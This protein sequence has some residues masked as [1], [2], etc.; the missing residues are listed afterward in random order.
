M[1]GHGS[2][3]QPA[4]D[5]V[6][7]A[8][9][10]AV[11]EFA[12]RHVIEAQR[13]WDHEHR[14]PR[15][16]WRAAGEQGLLGLAMPERYGGAGLT[17][18]RFR[19]AITEELAAVGANSLIASINLH[20]DIVLPYLLDLGTDAQRLAL[21]PGCC[22]GGL[23]GAIALTEPGAGSDLRGIT[24]TARRDGDDWILTGSKTSITSGSQADFVIV[25]ARTGVSST[26]NRYTLFLVEAAIPGF[27]RGA[28]LQKIGLHAQD[29]AELF[30]DEIRVPGANVL[31]TAGMGLRHVMERLARERLSIAAFAIARTRAA[32]RW[33]VDYV[34][35]REVFGHPLS[36]M[37][38]TQFVL[39]EVS[40]EVDVGEALVARSAGLLDAGMLTDSAAAKAKWWTTEMQQRCINACLQLHGG[41]GYMTEMPIA[42][43][44]QDARIQTIYGGTT[45]IMKLIIAREMLR[46][47]ARR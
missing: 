38:H 11:R 27:T 41:Y 44:Y 39:A 15:T 22:G 34:Q 46:R 21:I 18:Y 33:T 45:E 17:E 43:A 31:G 24:T 36:E 5:S 37:Q 12:R 16:A 47:P 8:L 1:P 20:D 2:L 3:G 19:R 4:H 32:L 28:A 14:I 7:D 6:L 29:T 26:A 10:A 23:I 40:T 13:D 25:L 42:R 35:Q 30:F 9:R